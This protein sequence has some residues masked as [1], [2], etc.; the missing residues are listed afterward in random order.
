MTSAGQAVRPT[1]A[2][3]PLARSAALFLDFDGTLAELAPSPGEVRVG[4]DVI[5]LVGALQRHLDGAL[6]IVTGRRLG[7]LDRM[8]APLR[9]PGAGLHGAELRFADGAVAAAQPTAGAARLAGQLRRRF[10]ADP[11]LLVEDK[12][13]AVALHFR[14]AP[15]RADECLAAMRELAAGGGLELIGGKQVIEARPAGA[16]K[17][18]A[19]RELIARQ[20]F[21]G[22]APVFVGDDATD[23]DGFAAVAAMG[24]YGVKVGAGETLAEFGCPSIA[25]MLAWLSRSVVE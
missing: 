19:V 3:A 7:D 11:R 15:E 17:G 21:R 12:G 25:D 22:R 6:A 14:R 16:D 20:P 10:G 24:G 9:L 1:A 2:P 8:L 5:A 13:A 4:A 23:E 18:H